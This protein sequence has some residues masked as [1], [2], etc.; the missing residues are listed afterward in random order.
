[1]TILIKPLV[2]P[3]ELEL[4][5]TEQY[6]CPTQAAR[7]DAA[8]LTNTNSAVRVVTVYVVPAGGAAVA[9]STLIQTRAL[10]P[11]ETYTCPELAGQTLSLGD[12]IQTQCT[13]AGVSFM[14]SG[15]EIVS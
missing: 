13:G 4:L 12:A 5:L 15:V 11:R 8:T 6:V 7:I 10:A 1:M 2:K 3:K 9:G 14:V